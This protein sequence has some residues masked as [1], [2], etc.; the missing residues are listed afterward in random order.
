MENVELTAPV[1][2]VA[3]LIVALVNTGNDPIVTRFEQDEQE[4]AIRAADDLLSAAARAIERSM[5]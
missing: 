2:L 3:A 5:V 1:P 4:R